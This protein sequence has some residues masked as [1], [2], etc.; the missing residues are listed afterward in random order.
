MVPKNHFGL[1]MGWIIF[2]LAILLYS[3]TLSHGYV[4]DDAIVI[5]ENVFTQKGVKGIPD[6]LKHDT[7]YGFFQDEG[8]AN[9]VAGG[10]YRPFTLVMFAV[11]NELFGNNPFIG[12]LINVILYAIS[13]MLIYLVSLRVFSYQ[14]SGQVL[15][16]AAMASAFFF[17]VHPV[18]TEAVAN[19][20][21]R[22][23]IMALLGGLTAMYLVM[24]RKKLSFGKWVLAFLA[25]SVALFSKEN[26]V[27]FIAAIPL[28][29]F[30]LQ[31][32]TISKTLLKSMPLFIAIILF[33]VVRQSVLG[34]GIGSDPPMELMN[35][36]FLKWVDG[37]FIPFSGGEKAATILVI[38]LSY[39]RLIIFPYP[40]T[41][42]YYPRQIEIYD[43]NDFL[44]L[45]SVLII[46]LLTW[47][48]IVKWKKSPILSFGL[49]FFG[50]ALFPYTNIFFPI[51]TNLSERFLYT[52]SFG[53]ALV[54]G[55]IFVMALKRKKGVF[56]KGLKIL[57][58]IVVIVFL[59]ITFN[60]NMAWKDNYTLFKTDVQTS[61]RSAKIH[62]AMAGELSVRSPKIE[63]DDE[64]I[65]QLNIAL[66]H[67]DKAI[68]IHPRYKNAFLIKGN[69]LYF[70]K[71]YE[72]AI[73]T[74][75]K[76]LQLDQHYEE[77]LRNIGVA[78]RDGGRFFGEQKGNIEMALE[79]L[80]KAVEYLPEDYETLRLLGVAHG[81]RGNHMDA[82]EY[83]EKAAEA[84]PDEA[85]AWYNLGT[86]Y[87]NA[88]NEDLGG[89]YRNKA[90]EID[91]E[92]AE[93]M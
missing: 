32:E 51:G 73:A 59:L 23:E 81:I 63:D 31:R 46:G 90:V 79:F 70:L 61:S 87:L 50:M 11:E 38:I 54:I 83:F 88:G 69:I 92:I 7:F 89:H 6:L 45:F 21:G 56:K 25:M 3:N 43:F 5:T 29:L 76:A 48:T 13:C 57:G 8:K 60:R 72:E 27:V 40:L 16:W 37:R 68:D 77:A 47:L 80:K 84:R 78:Y 1:R 58:C 12:H 14:L 10:R 86:A 42:D 52:P 65:A 19:I 67:A 82:I 15:I 71:R 34:F 44:P 49:L 26:A 35:N 36:P 85:A 93:K 22:D 17:T 53:A 91:P 18:H 28:G 74:Y 62:N 2:G 9:L 24:K 64:R 4:Q 41:H 75:K 55:W 30:L 33:F 20:K 66:E 39:L